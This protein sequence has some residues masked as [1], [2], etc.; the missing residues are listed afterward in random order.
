MP[1]KLEI[2]LVNRTVNA[3]SLAK[4][5]GQVISGHDQVSSAVET[6]GRILALIHGLDAARGGREKL[7][8][9]YM[10]I[11]RETGQKANILDCLTVAQLSLAMGRSN[12]VHAALILGGASRNF[13]S[14][15]QRLAHYRIGCGEPSAA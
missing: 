2:L 4:K 15:A 7:D 9:K 11:A 12:V 10:A 8:R 5:A 1:E 3:L 13:L 6:G 14:E